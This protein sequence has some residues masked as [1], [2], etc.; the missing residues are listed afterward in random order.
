[1]AGIRALILGGASLLAVSVP[2]FAQSAAPA[3]A[4]SINEG[5]VIIVEARRRSED[6]QDVPNSS[7]SSTSAM[8]AN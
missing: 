7:A 3:E 1:M 2:A 8:R 4:E 6:V 5:E